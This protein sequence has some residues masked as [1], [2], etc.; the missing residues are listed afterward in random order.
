MR[1]KIWANKEI[2]ME[3]KYLIELKDLLAP[4]YYAGTEE[5]VCTDSSIQ[6]IHKFTPNVNLAIKY[7]S[8]SYAEVC[9][10]KLPFYKLCIVEE[11][12]FE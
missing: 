3:V 7:F 2:N 12:S 6:T 8:K 4:L 9:L 1:K 10:N 5:R 11:H